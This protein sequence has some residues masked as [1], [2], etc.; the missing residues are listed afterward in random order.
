MTGRATLKT[1]SGSV[2]GGVSGLQD[3]GG[4]PALAFR[5]N[6]EL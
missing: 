2:R 5:N 3:D 6:L 4:K 1:V